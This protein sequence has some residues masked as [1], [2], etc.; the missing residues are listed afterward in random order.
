M[1]PPAG[2]DARQTSDSSPPA[3]SQLRSAG[4]RKED[5][6]RVRVS[7]ACD[8]LRKHDAL[9]SALVYFATEQVY[10]VNIQPLDDAAAAATG[11]RGI[12]TQSHPSDQAVNGTG[13]TVVSPVDPVDG[14]PAEESI[15]FQADQTASSLDTVGVVSSRASLEPA[16]ETDL[17]THYV[18]PSS[19]VSFL[20]R[21]QKSLHQ[22]SS[23]THS[24]SIF[25][26][27]D[28]P[29][30]DFDPAFFFLP[31]KSE[32]EDL[33][34]RY[35]DF[36]VPTHRFLHR[37]TI[38]TW[39]NE[40]YHTKGSMT[41]EKDALGRSALL[42][43]I[44][45]QAIDY[46]PNSNAQDNSKIRHVATRTPSLIEFHRDLTMLSARYFLAADHRLS[47]ERGE[48]RLTSVQARLCQCFFLL[49]QS[50]IN[51]CWNLFGTTAH[52]ALAIGLNRRRRWDTSNRYDLIELEC[53][54]RV[55]WCA[56]SLDN[57]LS[58]SLGRPR[59]FK[60]EDIDQELPICVNDS[61][62]FRDRINTT[63]NKTQSIMFAPVAHISLSRIVSL[64]LRD[65]YPI[66]PLSP[67]DRVKFALRYSSDLWNWRLN[68]PK[69]LEAEELDSSMLLP[70]Y[71]RQRNV[72]NLS[73]WHA[74]I[75]V[76]RPFLLSNFASL[77]R[78]NNTSCQGTVTDT[79]TAKNVA[80]CLKAAMN[81]VK[82]VDDLAQA[83]QM[84]RAF[85]FTAYY[86]FCAVVVLYVY[87]IQ[88]QCS[89][90]E[91]YQ[92]YF[93][94]AVKCQNQIHQ[95]GT[96][97]SLHQRYYVVLEELR[98]EAVHQMENRS[99]LAHA[100]TVNGQHGVQNMV[101]SATKEQHSNADTAS[102]H[103]LDTGLGNGN[104]CHMM[105]DGNVFGESPSSLMAEMTSWGEFA[106]LVTG[107]S[108]LDMLFSGDM[109]SSW[110]IPQNSNFE[111]LM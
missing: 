85:W 73:F 27:G 83:G 12:S 30:P 92:T 11:E 47:K 107:G 14:Y 40:F 55:F 43:M 110:D 64:V 4:R 32:A 59:T 19:G 74:L 66:F 42:L 86:S 2:H 41:N 48:V 104:G 49:S 89:L 20:R 109:N 8:R 63:L 39:L 91:T 34:A 21:V 87:C 58:A 46:M 72:L 15:A 111:A 26:F 38:E 35:F 78:I 99:R 54:R 84:F 67:S 80:E 7:R 1:T 70:L 13:D 77:T 61:S 52:L 5:R 33:V 106:S 17:Q 82:V 45:A 101:Q 51:H 22:T 3:R 25:A 9:E 69:F 95:V 10:D 90:P 65:L 76:Y 88:Q 37:P 102:D 100:E 75:L 23:F 97:E 36:A 96:K 98:R 71:Q 79:E 108:G 57:Y 6:G 31:P 56:Y 29:L 24:S 103:P 68:L 44:F 50:R 93:D 18:G 60:D 53:C 94:A 62:I 16:Q 81:I 28:A 105:P